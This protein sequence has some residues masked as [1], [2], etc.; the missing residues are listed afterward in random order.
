[1]GDA[2][3]FLTAILAAV[4]LAACGTRVASS[5]FVADPTMG[6]GAG[7]V[8][9][10]P[11]GPAPSPG[12]GNPASDTG[13]TPGEIKVGLIVSQTSPLGAEAFS[14]PMYGALAYFRALNGRG[15]LDHRTVRVIVC[16]DGAT[17]AGN[18]QCVHKLVDNDKVFA[19]AGNS[20]FNYAGAAYV[21]DHDVP[22]IGGQPIGNAYDQ[23]PHLYSIYGSDAPRDG[24]AVGVGGR[25]FGGTEVEHFFASAIN[26]RTAGV[27]YYNQSDSQRFGNLTASELQLEGF[28]VVREQVDLA[29]PNFDAAA[30]DM[31][32]HHVEVMFDAL[33][34]TGNVNLCKAMDAVHFEVKAK[35]ST[36]QSWN[37]SVRTQYAQTPMCRN[38]LYVTANDLNYNDT[39]SPVVA[40]FRD[41]IHRA[42]PERD[43]RLSMWEVEGWASAQW[44]TDA[45]TSC[46][47]A[48]TRSC[49]E[50][51]MQRRQPY[52]GHGLLTPR[53]FVV[54][55][56]PGGVQH[57][58]LSAAQW[59][60]SAFAGKGGWVSR[61]PGGPFVC[62]DVPSVGYTP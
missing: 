52:D 7:P 9:S 54:N 62:Y 57:N 11:E 10:A 40:Q 61:T 35:V 8:A 2:R 28:T 15:G 13:V 53:S 37:D 55:P 27:V 38:S 31:Q 39:Q 32:A 47:A 26:G 56:H 48:V 23:Y 41:D 4:S 30:I 44:L 16:D 36:V 19:F 6:P 17:G 46:G 33:D 22:D 42:F 43:N 49:V 18:L 34:D 14:P 12:A 59:Q 45:M 24:K 50:R 58:C 3:R 29:V 21:N 5:S 60:D 51:F 25:L 20:I 1:V